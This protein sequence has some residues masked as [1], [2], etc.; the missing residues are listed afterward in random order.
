MDIVVDTSVFLAIA[1]NEARKRRIIELTAG[2]LAIAPEIL[3]YEI[4]NALSAMVKRRKLSIS[5]ALE[6]EKLASRISVRLISVD[7]YTSLQIALENNIYAYDAYFLQ[8]AQR[9]SRLLLTLDR[10][11]KQV[12]ERLGIEAL[13]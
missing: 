6:A 1:L 3:P 5:A 12:A 8:C 4:G 7:V 11:M 9:S 10:R 2:A 13:E